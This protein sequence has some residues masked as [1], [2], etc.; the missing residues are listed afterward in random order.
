MSLTWYKFDS[1]INTNRENYW[2]ATL[3]CPFLNAEKGRKDKRIMLSLITGNWPV[4]KTNL[5]EIPRTLLYYSSLRSYTS[6]LDKLVRFF[7]YSTMQCLKFVTDF[8]EMWVASFGI[9]GRFS[10][11]SV[12]FK[13]YLTIQKEI[14]MIL[15]HPHIHLVFSLCWIWWRHSVASAQKSQS[16]CYHWFA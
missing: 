8:S 2:K 3:S 14:G 12:C 5:L 10:A 9:I 7:F 1:D 11:Q 13:I 16:T 6:W 15:K 4:P